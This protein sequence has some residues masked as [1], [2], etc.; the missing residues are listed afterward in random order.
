MKLI[1]LICGFVLLLWLLRHFCELIMPN[2]T[3]PQ[4]L[5][6]VA[7]SEFCLSNFDVQSPSSSGKKIILFWK[8]QCCQ[9]WFNNGC[10]DKFNWGQK[11]IA[12]NNRK[13]INKTS[14]NPAKVWVLD[15]AGYCILA[16]FD[17]IV[18]LITSLLSVLMCWSL[19]WLDLLLND[20]QQSIPTLTSFF[21]TI[22]KKS[23]N[24]KHKW[25][26]HTD[27]IWHLN[28]LIRIYM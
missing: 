10:Q 25:G 1:I 4:K 11:D 28:T 16:E 13:Q 14:M 12:N 2:L 24:L 15:G 8:I 23:E 18:P 17:C 22:C 6:S 19:V 21:W 5:T 7:L 3:I 26:F 20:N 27:N 9:L